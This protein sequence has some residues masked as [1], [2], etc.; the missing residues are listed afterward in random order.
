[1][2]KK[3]IILVA[4]LVTVGFFGYTSFARIKTE[5]KVDISWKLEAEKIKKI[6]LLGAEQNVNVVV[7]ETDNEYTNV[8]ISGKVSEGSAA[9]LKK[10]IKKDNAVEITLAKLDEFRL[11][12]TANGKDTLTLT[13]ELGKNSTYDTLEIDNVVGNVDAK[14]QP[15]FEGKYDLNT[16]EQ[17]EIK[18]VPETKKT[19]KEKVKI[20]TMGDIIVK[21]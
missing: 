11:M 16:N 21:K 15:S 6:A 7:K 5:K 17:G 9:Y 2:K 1:M 12:T 8:S 20:H 3:L 10:T 4:I 14:V 13:V 19:S 18:A